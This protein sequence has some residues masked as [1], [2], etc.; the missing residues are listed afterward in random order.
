MRYKGFS[1]ILF[2]CF[3]I[4]LGA[5][6]VVDQ[7]ETGRLTLGMRST[8]ST[9][10]QGHADQM[11]LGVGG[12]T[13]LRISPRVNTEWYADYITQSIQNRAK[14]TDGHIGWSVMYYFLYG[15]F[16]SP[17]FMP[18]ALAGHCFD[19]TKV[20]ALNNPDNMGER[21]SSAVQM[22]LG[23]HYRVSQRVDVSLTGQYMI[24]LG[25]DLETDVSDE[26][27]QISRHQG[28]NMESHLLF[29]LSVNYELVELW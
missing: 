29:T 7:P 10:N 9:F 18:Y 21:W 17:D 26:Q 24:H 5:Q 28:A 6:P 1:L 16:R 2:L 15:M 4:V 23:T 12:H 8:L 25:S 11:G 19:Y 22:G 27:V 20:A 13:R 3:T 14:R